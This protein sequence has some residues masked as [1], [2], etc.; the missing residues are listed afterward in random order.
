MLLCYYF[1]Q[2]CYHFIIFEFNFF[3]LV[4]KHFGCTDQ[5]SGHTCCTGYA[6]CTGTPRLKQRK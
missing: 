4:I 3:K 1:S 2:N 5:F 6:D